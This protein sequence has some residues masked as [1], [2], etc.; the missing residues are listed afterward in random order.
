MVVIKRAIAVGLGFSMLSFASV[1]QADITGSIE[2]TI[3]LESGCLINNVNNT[4][5]A[6]D[7]D[8]G[9]IDFGTHTTLF[10][11]ASGQ[12]LGTGGGISIQCTAGV[13]P[14]LII[15]DGLHDGDATGLGNRAMQH[16]TTATQFVSYNLMLEDGTVIESGDN[17]ELD[18]DGS[19]QIVVINGEA[20]G[21]PGLITGEY[22]DTVTVLLEI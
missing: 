5:D 8:F 14:N 3:T 21:A 1:A 15:Q 7:V 2:A 11:E 9:T 10:S 19:A 20:F 16:E 18:D 17:I 13:V 22:R 12:V 6:E 4:A